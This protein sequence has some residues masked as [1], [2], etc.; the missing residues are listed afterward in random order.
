MTDTLLEIKHELRTH[1]SCFENGKLRIA[2]LYERETDEREI[3]KALAKEWGTGGH[4]HTYLDGTTGFVDYDSKG[5]RFCGDHFK[6]LM[7]VPWNKVARIIRKMI[8]D[9]DFLSDQEQ[10]RYA[11]WKAAQPAAVPAYGNA[12]KSIPAAVA[13]P[14]AHSVTDEGCDADDILQSGQITFDDLLGGGI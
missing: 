1:G 12:A 10:A 13:E 6:E 5:F 2:A 4:S 8:D 9:G 3:A 11:E 14:A 7:T